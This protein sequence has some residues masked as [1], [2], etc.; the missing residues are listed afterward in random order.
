MD[1][2]FDSKGVV[3][4]FKKSKEDG[5]PWFCAIV[6]ESIVRLTFLLIIMGYTKHNIRIYY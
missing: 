5:C 4:T 6:L 2:V 1:F 3:D